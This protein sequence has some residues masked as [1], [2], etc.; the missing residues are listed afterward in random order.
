MPPYSQAFTH[1][2]TM[3]MPDMQPPRFLCEVARME[4]LTKVEAIV[5]DLTFVDNA[6]VGGMQALLSRLAWNLLEDAV[7]EPVTWMS[8][9]HTFEPVA[10]P[11]FL[12]FMERVR[13]NGSG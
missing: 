10:S 8:L 7:P 13:V 2:T 6:K 5:H 11:I 9:I 1:V 4:Q 12:K 3:G